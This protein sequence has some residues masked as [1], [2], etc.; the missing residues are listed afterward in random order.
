MPGV[1]RPVAAADDFL[2]AMSAAA[3]VAQP[4]TPPPAWPPQPQRRPGCVISSGAAIPVPRSRI[5]PKRLAVVADFQGWQ[6]LIAY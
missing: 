3:R 4:D 1:R 5:V 6:I 2:I